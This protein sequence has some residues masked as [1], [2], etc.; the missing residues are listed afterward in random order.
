MQGKIGGL[1]FVNS[2]AYDAHVRMPRGSKKKA[3][4]NSTLTGNTKK[5]KGGNRPEKQVYA[6]VKMFAGN[7]KESQLWQ[8]IMSLV[9]RG[10]SNKLIDLLTSMEGLELNAAYPLE[11]FGL[12][13]KLNI[14]SDKQKLVVHLESDAVP[15]IQKKNDCY[16]Y[17]LTFLFLPYN[18]TETGYITASTGWL[19]SEAP[20]GK[21]V[22]RFVKPPKA[23]CYL[24]C[25]GLEW[26]E[27]HVATNTLATKGMQFITAGTLKIKG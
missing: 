26:G 21:Q 8:K 25:L 11:R 19:E 12:L 5:L 27:K 23:R 16:Q 7:F 10:T 1:V 9:L 13:P 6:L 4:V 14:Q 2:K 20:P 3:T 18:I 15:F 24:L 22:F 17:V